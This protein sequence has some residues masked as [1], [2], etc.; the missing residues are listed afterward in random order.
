MMVFGIGRR[1]NGSTLHRAVS[2]SLILCIVSLGLC[3]C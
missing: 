2:G 1:V 3:L